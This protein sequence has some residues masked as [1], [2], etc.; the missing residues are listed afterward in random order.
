MDALEML[1]KNEISDDDP[2][3]VGITVYPFTKGE[4]LAA[5]LGLPT[6]ADGTIDKFGSAIKIGRILIGF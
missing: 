1:R 4:R 6:N 3:K 2:F 5:G